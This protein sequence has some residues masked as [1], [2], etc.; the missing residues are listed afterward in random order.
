MFSL[1]KGLG[2]TIGSILAGPEPFIAEARRTRKLFGGGMR[3]VDI[4]AATALCAL[5]NADRLATDHENAGQL[6]SGLRTLDGLSLPEPDT[7]IVLVNRER[8]GLTATE[9]VER[10]ES[11]GVTA[12]TTGEY[13]TRICTHLD[14][15]ADAIDTAIERI[16]SALDD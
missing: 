9:V 10:C 12:G 15:D 5:E 1:S 13:T 3:Q 16:G 4:V 7:N 2:A 11:V 6:A 14:V 8:R